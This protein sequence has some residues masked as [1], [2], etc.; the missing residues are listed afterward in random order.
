MYGVRCFG[1][2][3]PEDII[4]FTRMIRYRR[5]FRA[6]RGL[7]I[8]ATRSSYVTITVPY[9]Y[10][11]ILVCDASRHSGQ[12]PGT[13]DS[14]PIMTQGG[15]CAREGDGGNKDGPTGEN[16]VLHSSFLPWCSTTALTTI[17][18]VSKTWSRSWGNSANHPKG[19]R[20][21]NHRIQSS[22]AHQGTLEWRCG[23]RI[24]DNWL[25]FTIHQKK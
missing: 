5:M 24:A 20:L 3:M 19:T 4:R 15:M 21:S 9:T 13:C 2:G 16:T 23:E 17:P 6:H 11:H 22:R 12:F 14:Y 25:I 1:L 7:P 18:P 8:R 10:I